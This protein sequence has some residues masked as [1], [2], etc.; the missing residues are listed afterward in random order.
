MAKAALMTYE[1]GQLYN[2]SLSDLQPDPEQPRKY[3]DEL[4]LAE[5]KSSIE[6]HGI[7]QPIIVRQYSGPRFQDNSLRW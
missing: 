1:K 3:F 7:L 5:L 2:L 6:Q 4:A